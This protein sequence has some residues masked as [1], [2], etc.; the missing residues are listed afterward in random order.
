MTPLILHLDGEGVFPDVA[1]PGK[2]TYLGRNAQPIRL[3]VIEKGTAAGRPSVAI[4][5][6]LADGHIVIAET[7]ARLFCAAARAIVAK[8]PNLFEGD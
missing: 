8:Y 4:R 5:L 7:T 6:D 1:G 3:A 2:L